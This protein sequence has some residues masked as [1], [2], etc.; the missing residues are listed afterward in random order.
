[1]TAENAE[2]GS[3]RVFLNLE[4]ADRFKLLSGALS[5]LF[6]CLPLLLGEQL[7]FFASFSLITFLAA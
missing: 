3:P 5:S 6:I 7:F 2:P 1:L 4:P